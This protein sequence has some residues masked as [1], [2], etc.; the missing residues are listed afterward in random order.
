MINSLVPAFRTNNIHYAIRDIIVLAQ[1]VAKTGMD[2][3]YLNIGDPNVYDFDTP[4]HLIDS[5]VEALR[6]NKNGYAPSS[7]I[8]EA[9]EA[10]RKDA[11]ERKKI[12]SI[13]DIFI[14]TGAAEAIEICLTALLNTG[15]NFLMPT[16]G[17]PLYNAIESKLELEPN[18]YY[19]DESNGWAPD[20]EDIKSKVNA[21]TRA[22]VLINPNNPTGALYKREQ[23]EQIVEVAKEHNLVI[24]ADEIYD[25]LIFDDAEMVSIASLDPTVT[26][27]T[28]SG[29]SKNYMAP[30]F[31]LG[32][33]IVSGEK[34]LTHEFVEAINK[35]LRSRVSANH[36]L[37][38]CIKPALEGDQTHLTETI[39]KLIRRRDIVVNKVNKIDGIDLVAPQGAFYAFPSIDVKDDYHF[40]EELLKATG[41]VVVPGTGF[42]Q[43]PG[44]SHFRIVI[45]PTEKT[46]EQSFDLIGE[47][48]KHYND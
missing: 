8:P 22:I 24:F 14:T 29:M 30:G 42:G 45:C 1:G 12:K 35:I 27:V 28:F 15:E 10:V 38:Y 48:Y 37:Q 9:I 36:P 11:E 20:I 17:Y 21:K 46:L 7:G 34:R 3:H 19:L 18:P 47:F 4:S 23:L 2:M 43:K 31:R 33:G 5:V 16:P 32:W 13:Q 39:E 41:V 6:S 40:C 44:S 26:C 25:K